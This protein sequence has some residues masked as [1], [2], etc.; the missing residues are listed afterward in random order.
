M[1]CLLIVGW[2]AACSFV[3][4]WMPMAASAVEPDGFRHLVTLPLGHKPPQ[5]HPYTLYEKHAVRDVA[6]APDGKTLAAAFPAKTVRLFEVPSGRLKLVL[7]DP[8]HDCDA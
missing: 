5:V 8:A 1:R 4:Q 2:V 3:F 7:K 6:F